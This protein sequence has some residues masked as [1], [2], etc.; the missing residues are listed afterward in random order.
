MDDASLSLKREKH[1]MSEKRKP[2]LAAKGFHRL[3]RAVVLGQL[4]L[5]RAGQG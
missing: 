5:F 1:Q 4:L 2:A 3:A